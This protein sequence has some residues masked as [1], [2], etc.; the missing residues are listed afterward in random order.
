M[1]SI[2]F[3]QTTTSTM[4][5]ARELARQG[6]EEGTIVVAGTQ[7]QGRGRAGSEWLSPEGGAW[8]SVILKP[9]IEPDKTH[10]VVFLAGVCVCGALNELCGLDT[11]IRWP[12]DI[13][14]SGKKL[15]GVLGETLETDAGSYAIV[16]IG[17][18]TNFGG[19]VLPEWLR[20]EATT[21]LDATGGRVD[22]ETII[23][24]IAD[25]LVSRSAELSDVYPR[26]LEEWLE[27][28]DTVGQTVEVDGKPAGRAV[29]LDEEGF[30]VVKD[31]RG[32]KRIVSG[33]IRY[34]GLRKG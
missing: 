31:E 7:T 1:A 29:R 17:V 9:N 14:L 22:N 16:G 25:L 30:L 33:N 13:M 26:I 24:R 28:S 32:E 3:Y 2:E 8:F 19:S 10:R 27:Y 6:R 21:T 20:E 12:N 15:A 11:T 34:S 5:V 4:D 23:K 18:N